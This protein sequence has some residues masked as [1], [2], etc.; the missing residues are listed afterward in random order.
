MTSTL[1]CTHE[2]LS[3]ATKGLRFLHEECQAVHESL[4][5]VRAQ[6]SILVDEI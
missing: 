4:R 2:Q 5:P 6:A 1:T 3:D